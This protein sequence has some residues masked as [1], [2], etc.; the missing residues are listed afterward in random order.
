MADCQLPKWKQCCC[1]CKHRLTDYHHC[2]I[3]R[4][5]RETVKGCVCSIPKGYICIAPELRQ[6]FSEWTEHGLCELH[7]SGE[8]VSPWP[9]TT[10]TNEQAVIE[11]Q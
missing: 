1:T 7:E 11:G 2:T 6:A 10:D 5:L 4:D 3:H 8:S 9:P